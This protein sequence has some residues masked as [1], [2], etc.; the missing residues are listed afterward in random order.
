M[1]F[2]IASD[3]D[4]CQVECVPALVRFLQRQGFR[5]EFED[6]RQYGIAQSLGDL[7][8]SVTPEEED[9]L[10]LDFYDSEEFENLQPAEGAVEG[11]AALCQLGAVFN[12]TARDVSMEMRTRE[13]VSRHFGNNVRD[14]L[15]S[16]N[17]RNPMPMPSKGEYC[18]RL[19]AKVFID[20]HYKHLED[21]VGIVPLVF[22]F[23]RPWNAG[24]IPEGVI[25]VQDY[26]QV[27][28]VL[29]NRTV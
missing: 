29:K 20:D 28:E 10:F 2:V 14:V 7:G 9:K 1:D 12:I 22:S 19:G 15:F 24:R 11:I 18:R 13:L 5:I 17:R 27:C 8:Y 6:F 23:P 26:L 3:L 16:H 4:D 21:C 25:V